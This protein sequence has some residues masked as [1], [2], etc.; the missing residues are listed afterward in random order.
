MW[1]IVH[2]NALELSLPAMASRT[3]L[4]PVIS[5]NPGFLSLLS[6]GRLHRISVDK[7]C[8]SYS[9]EQL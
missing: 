9:P 3:T 7:Y 8:S 5:R 4:V 1:I 2:Q 6:F